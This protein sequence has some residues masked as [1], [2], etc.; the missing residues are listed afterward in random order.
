MVAGGDV[1][2]VPAGLPS[3]IHH[4]ICV[5]AQRKTLMEGNEGGSKVPSSFSAGILQQEQ[6]GFFLYYEI[7]GV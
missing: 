6:L 4:N 3:N 1:T 7:L 5:N 2:T